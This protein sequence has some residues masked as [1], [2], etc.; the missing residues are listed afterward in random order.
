MTISRAVEPDVARRRTSSRGRA[1]PLPAVAGPIGERRI[2][3]GRLAV[4]ATVV[5]WISYF[6]PWLTGQFIDG[7]AHTLRAK[8]EAVSYLVVVT[9]L[10]A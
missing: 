2:A 4:I 10:T 7:G 3:L 9:L 8:I 6:V 1:N 5:A